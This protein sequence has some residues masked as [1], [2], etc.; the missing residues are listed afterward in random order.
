MLTKFSVLVRT[1]FV[2]LI[3]VDHGCKNFKK[4]IEKLAK[5][6]KELEGLGPRCSKAL[7]QLLTNIVD[8][9]E[10]FRKEVDLRIDH[11]CGIH[12]RCTNVMSKSCLQTKKITELAAKKDFMVIL[13]QF[14]NTYF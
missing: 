9:E 11:Y 4:K 10:L 5:K 6:H 7:K 1:C 12:D 3:F 8:N 14:N 2:K 13:F